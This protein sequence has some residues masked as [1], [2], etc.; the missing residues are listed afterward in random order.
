MKR[1]FTAVDPA[2]GR[3]LYSGSADDLEAVEATGGV[4]VLSDVEY[5]D[6]YV[7]DG[8]HSDVPEQSA[9]N[10]EFNWNTKVWEDTRTLA[11]VRALKWASIK[12]ARQAATAAPLMT[13]PFGVIDA[14]EKSIDNVRKTLDGL[15]SAVALGQEI[16][17]FEWTMA[18][19]SAQLITLQELQL[20]SV[21]LLVRGQ[22][23]FATARELRTQIYAAASI[24]E[25]EAIEWPHSPV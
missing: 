20:V 19:D 23:A 9:P 7:V 25:V 16:E 18:D 21:L 14:N 4:L 15:L 22:Q 5:V 12:A 3:V 10:T 2:T 1:K 24:A 11:Q 17:P 6:G 13:T 8:L